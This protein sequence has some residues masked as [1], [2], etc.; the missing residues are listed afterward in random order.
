MLAAHRTG[1]TFSS[2]EGGLR[3]GGHLQQLGGFHQPPTSMEVVSLT[4][5]S[6]AHLLE[7]LT[8]T[9][10]LINCSSTLTGPLTSHGHR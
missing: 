5:V 4:K 1:D 7:V 9:G 6:T 10:S 3:H 8:S 2:P